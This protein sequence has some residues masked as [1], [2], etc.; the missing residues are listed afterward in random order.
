MRK[1]VAAVG[2][3]VEVDDD[4]KDMQRLDR[5]RVLLR[6]PLR[7]TVE[8]LVTT[9]I[10]GDTHKI[11]IVEENWSEG[12]VCAQQRRSVWGSSDEIYSDEGDSGTP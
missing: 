5:A 10:D 8:H 6:T 2:D 12:L 1:I 11:Y 9:T 4:F 3:L 7:P